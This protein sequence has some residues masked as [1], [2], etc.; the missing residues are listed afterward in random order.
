MLR[1]FSDWI[2]DTRL[3]VFFQDQS[4]WLIPIS[5]S[6]HILAIG[7]LLIS[8]LL[9]NLRL[10]GVTAFGRPV[11]QLVDSLLLWM[12]GALGFLMLTGLIQ[13]ITEPKRQFLTPAF[14]AKMIMIVIAVIMTQRFAHWV[15]ANAASFAA[16]AAAASPSARSRAFAVISSVLWLAIITCGRFIGYTHT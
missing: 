9:L 6:I 2:A 16:A 1:E 7:V 15:R 13:I 4:T 10:L 14:W 11:S 5:Q 8:A 12:W 3:S